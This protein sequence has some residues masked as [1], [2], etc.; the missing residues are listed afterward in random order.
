MQELWKP[1][2]IFYCYIIWIKLYA[3]KFY[4]TSEECKPA[5]RL[6]YVCKATGDRIKGTDLYTSLSSLLTIF[7]FLKSFDI[8]NIKTKVI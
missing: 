6:G 1:V 5:Q 2:R 4:N 3:C 7:I 8:K